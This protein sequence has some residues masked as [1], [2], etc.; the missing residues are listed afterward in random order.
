M[1]NG[2]YYRECHL[3][4][5]GLI[6]LHSYISC[7]FYTKSSLLFQSQVEFSTGVGSKPS[8]SPKAGQVSYL[9]EYPS[10]STSHQAEFSFSSDR[11]PK[12]KQK[13]PRRLKFSRLRKSL[14]R[15]LAKIGLPCHIRRYS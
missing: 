3:T 9:G 11:I 2:S 12:G 4:P 1:L 13:S 8:G 10:L 7:H 14:G 6:T 15:K 5:G